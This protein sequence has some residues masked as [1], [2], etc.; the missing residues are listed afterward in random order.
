MIMDEVSGRQVLSS[1]PD[2]PVV[3]RHFEPELD[4]L[5][6]SGGGPVPCIEAVFDRAALEISRGC[7]QGCRFCQAGFLY[8]PMRERSA[9][10]TDDD[11]RDQPSFAA[12]LADVGYDYKEETANPA[13][14]LFLS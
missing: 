7:N 6:D 4:P 5:V 10:P 11:V 3:T 1:K 2:A 13:Y 9:D 14:Q 12:L 8:R